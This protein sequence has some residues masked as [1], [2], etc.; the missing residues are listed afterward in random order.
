MVRSIQDWK[1][2]VNLANIRIKEANTALP[3]P[4][5]ARLKSKKGTQD[6][7]KVGNENNEPPSGK[8]SRN[9]KY[10]LDDNV[11]KKYI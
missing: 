4:F 2:K 7:Y 9:K 3:F 10:N 8:I 11:W 6:M 1:K 5:Q